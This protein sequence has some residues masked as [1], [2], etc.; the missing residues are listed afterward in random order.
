MNPN[1]LIPEPSTLLLRQLTITIPNRFLSNFL[2]S[3]LTIISNSRSLVVSAASVD[4][5]T[6][7]FSRMM[8]KVILSQGILAWVIRCY[9]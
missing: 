8:V 3:R 9:Q 4:Q 1:L 2:S 5:S 7:F 6:G